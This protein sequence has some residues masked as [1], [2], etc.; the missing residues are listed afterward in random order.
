MVLALL[1]VFRDASGL[2]RNLAKSSASP[3]RSAAADILPFTSVLSCLVKE[4]PIQYLGLP[5][6]TSQLS[7][8]DMQ[9]LVDRFAGYIPSWKAS[10]LK[11]GGRLN[12]VKSTLTADSIYHMLALDLPP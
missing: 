6:S 11:R 10:F 5:L 9:P 7:K 8:S 4:F 12:L 3:I 1:E 2:S